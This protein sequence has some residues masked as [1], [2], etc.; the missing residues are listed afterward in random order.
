MANRLKVILPTLILEEQSAFVLGRLIK[1]TVFLV[2][3]CVHCIRTRKRKKLL[4]CVKLDMTKAYDIVEWIFLENMILIM[5]FA[6]A[7]VDMVMR[8]IRS[9][10]FPVRLNG[11]FLRGLIP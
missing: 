9:V 1:D 11:F 4:C 6:Q 7:W 5:G 8:C 3:E 10:R 2:Y